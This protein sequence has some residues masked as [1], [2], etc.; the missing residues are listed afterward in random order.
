MN[1]SGFLGNA[2]EEVVAK[3]IAEATTLEQVLDDQMRSQVRLV[4]EVGLHTLRAG[5]KRLRP[6]LVSLAAS[7]TGLPFEVE[8][9][10]KLGSCVEMIHMATLIHDDVID[11]A[12]TRR[13]RATASAVFGNT[14]A[15]LSGDVLLAKAMQILAVDGDLEIIR[16]VSKVVVD[17]AEGEVRE[18]ESRG[19]FEL[20]ETEHR[21]I[22]KMKTA[23]F[24]Q[25]CCELGGLIANAPQ[26]MVESLGSY[27]YHIGMAFQIADDLLDYRGDQ[28]KTGK[29]QATDFRE[30]CATLPLIY[31]RDL[32]T[33]EERTFASGKF[34]NGVSD[35]EVRMITGWMNERGAFAQA[36][37]AARDHL[38]TAL[39]SLA[40]LPPT[41]NRDL[42]GSVAEFVVTRQL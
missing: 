18:L 13:G 35:D 37:A 27:G 39:S 11:H 34:G 26:T 17:L 15:I 40:A 31:L 33:E 14:A 22:L 29:P 2:S 20:S 16:R 28:V 12:D 4:E 42:L 9:A 30:G 25:V 32:L 8:R 23:T 10:R 38:A 21:E 19:E 1:T 5:G 7:S 36:E 3:I 6:A 24:I 41:A